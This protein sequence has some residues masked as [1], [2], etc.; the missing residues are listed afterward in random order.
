MQWGQP[1][2]RCPTHLTP[3]L[4]STRWHTS[5]C[6]KMSKFRSPRNNSNKENDQVHLL[7]SRLNYDER[8]ILLYTTLIGNQSKKAALNKRRTTP[9]YVF[10]HSTKKEI[11]ASMSGW[12][13]FSRAFLRLFFPVA[14]HL[15]VLSVIFKS[16]R[17]DKTSWRCLSNSGEAD[18]QMVSAS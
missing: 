2:G 6:L 10:L 8:F 9:T 3:P 11:L 17:K 4:C 16:F 1:E 14:V 12:R 5:C 7:L 18:Y 13:L 15:P